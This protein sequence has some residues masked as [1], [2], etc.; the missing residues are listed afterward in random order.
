M[1]TK[2]KTSKKKMPVWA[3]ILCIFASVLLSLVFIVYVGE[4]LLFA[5]FFFRGA[6]R[7]MKIP[8]LWS[9]FVPQGFDKLGDDAYIM[10]GYHKDGESPSILYIVDEDGDA[11][12]KCELYDADGSAYTSHAGG[13]AHF[14]DWIYVAHNTGKET[15][16]CDM[17]LKA[18]VLDGDG[19]ATKIDSV[20]V[21]LPV[22]YCSIYDG[23]L[24]AGAFHREGTEYLMPE[25][26][27]L[28]TPCGD[29]NTAL[30]AVMTLDERTG[31]P[32]SDMPDLLFS[33]TSSVQGM[34]FT[35]SGKMVLS[36]SWGL[37]RSHLLVYDLEKAATG[38][39]TLSG[40]KIPV[41]YLDG[42]CLTQDVVCPPMAE[43][44]VYEDG[45]V[46]ILTESA[47]MKYLFGKL[48]SGN[49]VRSF[50]ID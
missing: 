35:N 20:L 25:S 41:V 38:T 13:V 18:D 31:K 5:K 26:H 34:C 33:T 11:A 21:P 7:E 16:Y 8:G 12:E 46:F 43:E 15:T 6:E 3:K 22:S 47:S 9:G 44:L 36:T 1:M 4:K 29:E 14:R 28:T 42:D 32:V 2:E 24:Y 23:K 37:T 30:M 17:F 10:S 40:A 45:R 49:Y 27:R 19:R 48:T 50:P 39:A